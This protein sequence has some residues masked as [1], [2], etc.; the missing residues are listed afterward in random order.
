MIATNE[1]V[2]QFSKKRMN[3]FDYLLMRNCPRLGCKVRKFNFGLLIKD[4]YFQVTIVIVIVVIPLL[5][6]E[7]TF[8][9]VED[10]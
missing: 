2:S 6:L 8:I 1:S 5:T 7:S 4:I 9:Y 3:T 10:L